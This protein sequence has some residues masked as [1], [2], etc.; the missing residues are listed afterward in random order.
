MQS[1]QANIDV[2]SLDLAALIAQRL[3]K[4]IVTVLSIAL[5]NRL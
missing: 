3:D 1:L 5:K 2:L 4:R